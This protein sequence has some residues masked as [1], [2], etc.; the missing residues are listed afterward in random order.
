MKSICMIFQIHQPRRFRKFRFFDMGTGQTYD[1]DYATETSIRQVVSHCIVPTNTLLLR[2]LRRMNGKFK[3]AFYLSGITIE[4]LAKYS[5]GVVDSF[6]ELAATGLVEFLGGTYS[7]SLASLFSAE[8]FKEE[9][10]CQH[11]AIRELTGR[12]PEVFMNT[13]MIYSDEIGSGIAGMGYRGAV[14]EGA[15]HVLGWK[16]PGFVYCNAINPK[17]KVLMR[18]PKLSNDL[19]FRFTD[20]QWKGFTAEKYLSRITESGQ[21]DET[22]NIG[23][24]YETFGISYPESSGI[25]G[26]LDHFLFMAGQLQEITFRTPSE[27][28]GLLQPVSLIN[29]PNPVSWIEDEHDVTLWTGNELQ[30]EALAKLYRLLPLVGGAHDPEIMRNWHALQGSDHFVY[31]ST[32]P[33]E[34]ILHNRRNPAPSPFEA[35]INY[36]NILNDFS[37]RLDQK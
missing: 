9:A 13:E 17:L 15:R 27:V 3:I 22:V 31:M 8:A 29:V 18:S 1:D 33:A 2:H 24:D 21:D 12:D 14:A 5:P 35:F 10:G 36:M 28:I 11:E 6:R 19:A 7:H 32:R 30:N 20:P 16:S 23:L 4:L 25:F 34:K 26:F 37:L